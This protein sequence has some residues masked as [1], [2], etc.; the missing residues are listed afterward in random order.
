MSAFFGRIKFLC[1]ILMVAF[2]WMG[3]VVPARAQSGCP[4]LTEQP[5][6]APPNEVIQE[7]PVGESMETAWK[8]RWAH[9]PGKGLYITG[10]W[11]KRTV[12]EDWMKVL[13]DARLADIFVPYH[14]GSPRFFD[15]TGFNFGL[16]PA[17]K[18]DAGYCGEIL[19]SVVVKEVRDRGVAWKNYEM[20]HRG[21]ELLLWATLGAGNYNYIMQYGFR[22]DGTISFRVGATAANLPGSEFEAH[23]H[24]GLWRL[25]IDLNGAAHDTAL[26]TKHVESTKSPKA[27]DLPMLFNDG[28]EGFADWEATKFT[29]VRVRDEL[30]KNS[31]GRQISYDLIPLRYGT[32]RHQEPFFHHD[33]WVTRYHGSDLFYSELP[34]YVSDKELIANSDVVLWYIS[35]VHHL[36]RNEDGEY[37]GDVWNGVAL[38]MWGGFD[39][40]PRNLFDH[41][42]FYP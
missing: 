20:V 8:V 1:V 36:P 41:T 6:Q 11:F 27:I 12:G 37:V 18:A 40:R 10:A 32:A 14:S 22:D 29:E 39:L 2:I 19:D 13:H 4:V 15:L 17:T 3:S 38:V 24:D 30:K 5:P 25:D 26:V 31:H 33:F 42:P 21:Q 34:N 35:P 16:V 23:M 9:A 7:F 28:V